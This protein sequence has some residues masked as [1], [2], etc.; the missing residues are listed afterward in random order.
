MQKVCTMDSQLSNSSFTGFSRQFVIVA[1]FNIDDTCILLT[2]WGLFCSQIMNGS[3]SCKQDIHTSSVKN[4]IGLVFLITIVHICSLPVTT[5]WNQNLDDDQFF[6][7]NIGRQSCCYYK[8]NISAF[9]INWNPCHQV[10]ACKSEIKKKKIRV[11]H[12]LWRWIT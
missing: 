8:T 1:S 2:Y 10:V 6:R 4:L 11:L 5:S 7:C 12:D 9:V 3:G